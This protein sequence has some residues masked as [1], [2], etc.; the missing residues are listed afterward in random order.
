MIGSQNVV[1]SFGFRLAMTPVILVHAINTQNT[2]FDDPED[3]RVSIL[4]IKLP[5]PIDVYT[6]TYIYVYIYM[7]ELGNER[8]P[9]NS[10]LL[11]KV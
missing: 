11:K 10:L 5:G 9:G 1:R 2:K 3:N 4:P 7:D 8:I 6:Y